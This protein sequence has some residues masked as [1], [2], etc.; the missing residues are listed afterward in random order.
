MGRDKFVERVQ[1][2]FQLKRF[3]PAEIH[4][5]LYELDV[6]ITISPNFD[7]I[8]DDYCRQASAGSYVIKTHASTDTISYLNKCDV[9]LLIKSHGSANDPDDLIFTS[10]DY[11]RARTKYSLFY[12]I[13]RSLALTHTF[14]FIGCG[15]DD[16]DLRMLFE[17]IKF[18]YGRMPL[19]FM[20]I[21]TGEVAPEVLKEL[22]AVMQVKHLAYSPNNGHRELTESLATL[23][24]LVEQRRDALS[25]ARNW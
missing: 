9:R 22:S 13:I 11:S 15:V 2:E 10:E 14:I 16:P 17:D 8:Y 18:T 7:N 12:D 4:K 6:A 1:A 5:N 23:V 3:K 20:T 19:H 25:S 21:P 24:Q